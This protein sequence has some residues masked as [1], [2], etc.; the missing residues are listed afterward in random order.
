MFDE[1]ESRSKEKQNEFSLLGLKKNHW[2]MIGITILIISLAS[3]LGL[4]FGL[5]RNKDTEGDHHYE[6]SVFE[7]LFLF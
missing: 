1:D 7:L 4:Y 5:N 2:I 3:G 6:K